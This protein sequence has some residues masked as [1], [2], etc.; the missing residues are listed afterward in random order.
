[1]SASIRAFRKELYEEHL[2][3]ASFLYEQ[4]RFHRSNAEIDWPDIASFEDRS[5]AH[6]DALVVGGELAI[7]ICSAHAKTGDFGEL[8][9]A[10]SVFCRHG[11][12]NYLSGVLQSLDYA[13]NEK[14]VAVADA[15]KY[16]LPKGWESFVEQ[17]LSRRD[18][19][20]TPLL[21]TVSGY[22]RLLNGPQLK[23]ALIAN[24]THTAQIV[25]ALGRIKVIDAQAALRACLQHADT[26][27]RYAALLAILRIGN[28]DFLQPYYACADKETWACVALGLGGGR[29]AGSVLLEIANSGKANSDC[30]LALGLLGDPA[31]LQ[32]LYDCLK[33]PELADSAALALSWI[34]GANLFEEVLMPEEV[35][36]EE[37]FESE[38]EA[39]LE[40]KEPPK[41]ADGSAFGENVMKRT[42]NNAVWKGWFADNASKFDLN[43]RYRSG[44]PYAPASLLEN[45]SNRRSDPQ[46]RKLAAEELVIRYG[47]DVPF[48][49]DMPVAQQLRALQDVE[50]WVNSNCGRFQAGGWY[51][52]GHPLASE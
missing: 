4:R 31:A 17:A 14:V 6:I 48:E 25:E 36:E 44:N 20:L 41:R 35:K 33:K 10:V 19:R 38:L 21:A 42:T 13:D 28:K 5:E 9:A 45:L 34:T 1:M 26:S 50:E 3:E 52:A 7:K 47:C 51:F 2:Q 32:T 16:E 8:F 18:P 12:A 37:L 27:I 30:L 11:K 46:L 15:L 23:Q 29:S 22:C 40:R 43:L 24:G 39:W 49:V